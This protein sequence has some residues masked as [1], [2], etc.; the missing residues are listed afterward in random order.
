MFS[1]H[2]LMICVTKVTGEET[3]EVPGHRRHWSVLR[4]FLSLFLQPKGHR[5]GNSRRRGKAVK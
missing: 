2:W 1:E 4:K 3:L 5:K